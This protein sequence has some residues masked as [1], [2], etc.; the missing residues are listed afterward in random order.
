MATPPTGVLRVRAQPLDGRTIL[1]ES[2]RSA[3]FHLTVPSYRSG[4][5][6]AEVIVQQ[7]S[8]GIL[9]GDHLLTE[10]AVEPGARLTV[11]AQSAT[12]VYPARDG[13]EARARIVLRV[14]DDAALA[15]LPG[16]VIPFRD[17]DYLQETEVDLRPGAR[18]ALAETITP[19]RVAMGERDAYARLDLRLRIRLDDRSLLIERARLEPA[20]RPLRALGRHGPYGC[21]G[22]LY[23]FGVSPGVLDDEASPAGLWWG[24]GCVDGLTV[25]RV[26]GETAQAVNAHLGR[27]ISRAFWAQCS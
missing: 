21:A 23:L 14:A 26:L 1:A 4:D 12:K 18:L 5:G 8:P 15:Y 9:P 27:L 20:A 19:G 25:V 22:A 10:I 24:H 16:E 13:G 2:Y 17:A 3:P 11:R 6:T 7:A